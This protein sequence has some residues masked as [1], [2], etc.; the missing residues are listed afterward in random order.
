[1]LRAHA[2]GTAVQAA[3]GQ[4]TAVQ[5]AGG[6]GTVRVARL[7]H[8]APTHGATGAVEASAAHAVPAVV[9]HPVP[10]RA[11]LPSPRRRHHSAS[12]HG[13]APSRVG[14]GPNA[15]AM[16]ARVSPS[17]TPRRKPSSPLR[18]APQAPTKPEPVDAVHV[19]SRAWSPVTSRPEDRRGA[20]AGSGASNDP[21]AGV[22]Q[23]GAAGRAVRWRPSSARPVRSSAVVPGGGPG[24]WVTSHGGGAGGGSGGASGGRPSRVAVGGAGNAVRALHVNHVQDLNSRREY[25]PA[26]RAARQGG[27]QRVGGAAEGGGVGAGAGG[28]THGVEPARTRV[29]CVRV[30]CVARAL[31]HGF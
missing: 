5:A 3:G 9:S 27:Y 6:Q 1:M 15:A 8:A 28:R 12:G 26:S 11:A 7:G 25:Q 20:S 24:G 4:G 13:A 10:H 31:A 17:A 14:G 19:H 22:V 29:R 16:L 2:V 23:S 30:A 18:E 21:E